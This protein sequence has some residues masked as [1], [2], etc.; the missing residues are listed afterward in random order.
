[1]APARPQGNHTSHNAV[2]SSSE[3]SARYRGGGP[4]GAGNPEGMTLA[5][6][7]ARSK[8]SSKSKRSS[9]RTHPEC[10]ARHDYDALS[11][12]P[13]R[14]LLLPHTK[15]PPPSLQSLERPHLGSQGLSGRNWEPARIC[16]ASV[17]K[18]GAA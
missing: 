2:L 9:S 16:R 10:R 6:T 3:D 13:S 11:T 7:G 14:T 4:K 5:R 12:R 1:M 17:N 18:M 8:S 15:L